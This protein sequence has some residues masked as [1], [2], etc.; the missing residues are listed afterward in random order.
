M[1]NQ[2]SDK[3]ASK[4][5]DAVERGMEKAT[6]KEPGEFRDQANADKKVEIGS[7]VT[8]NPIKGIDPKN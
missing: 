5:R 3:T 6:E 1:N 2:P 8:K 7:V 4:E